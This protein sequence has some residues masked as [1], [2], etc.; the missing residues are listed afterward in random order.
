MIKNCF[1]NLKLVF[2]CHRKIEVYKKLRSGEQGSVIFFYK[3]L[4]V[5]SKLLCT[6]LCQIN[7]DCYKAI[8]KLISFL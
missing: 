4:Q 2:C 3:S 8:S 6:F 7:I 5:S 1:S